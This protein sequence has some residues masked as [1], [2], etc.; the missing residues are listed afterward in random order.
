MRGFAEDF[1][2]IIARK[3]AKIIHAAAPSST[4]EQ[5]AA[6]RQPDSKSEPLVRMR[7]Y[8]L[9]KFVQWPAEAAGSIRLEMI[10][11]SRAI[12]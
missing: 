8:I 3:G 4:A 9:G 2:L 1:W 6:S 12:H 5:H 10:F 11:T 7:S